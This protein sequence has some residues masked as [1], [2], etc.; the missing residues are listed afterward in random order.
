M[1]L[2]AAYWKLSE[3]EILQHYRTIGEAIDIPIM[4]Y[5]NPPPAAPTCRWN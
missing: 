2:P 3:A 4:L 1:V 5:N